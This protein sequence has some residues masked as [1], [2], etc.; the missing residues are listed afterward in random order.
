MDTQRFR[1]GLDSEPFYSKSY[2]PGWPHNSDEHRLE[3]NV[4]A[5]G[6][7]IE[8]VFSQPAPPLQ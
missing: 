2:N 4:E 7:I 5:E 3:M 1:T 8:T 6:L